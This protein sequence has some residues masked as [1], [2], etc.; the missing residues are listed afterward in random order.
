M[1]IAY[2][3]T[4]TPNQTENLNA[5]E[6]M[7][8]EESKKL[9]YKSIKIIKDDG[10]NATDM[11]RPGLQKIVNLCNTGKVRA[12]ITTNENRLARNKKDFLSLQKIF[13]SRK[14]ILHCI[15]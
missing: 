11:N 10:K 2:C 8:V 9:G 4:S 5:Q 15:Q 1:V 12:I 14:I 13:A 6:R 7:C 3:R